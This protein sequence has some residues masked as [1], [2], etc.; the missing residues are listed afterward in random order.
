MPPQPAIIS[1]RQNW[2]D[3]P[4][5]ED[6]GSQEEDGSNE[7]GKDG[8]KKD[9]TSEDKGNKE[10]NDKDYDRKQEHTKDNTP[11]AS[12]TNIN[13]MFVFFHDVFLFLISLLS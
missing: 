7:G 5:E 2:S 6:E 4:I 11:A 10:D 8:S 3:G 1:T 9:N 13:G 12:A